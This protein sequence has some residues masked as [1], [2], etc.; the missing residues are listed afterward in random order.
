MAMN[1]AYLD[2]IANAGKAAV[3]HV[4]LGGGATAIGE[5][6]VTRQAIDWGVTADGNFSA[7]NNPLFT[8]PAAST[9]THVQ[10]WSAL[11]GGTLYG[12]KGVTSETF[13]GE[14]TYTVSSA[15]INHNAVV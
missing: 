11:T 8:V 14:G 4:S 2:L 7:T 3:T 9:V 15:V 12:A 6:G 1:S 13:N 10:F 5:L